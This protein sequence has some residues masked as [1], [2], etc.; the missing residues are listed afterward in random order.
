MQSPELDVGAMHVAVALQGSLRGDWAAVTWEGTKIIDIE[1][2][3]K[4]HKMEGLVWKEG[5]ER[6]Q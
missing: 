2:L 4:S 6:K 1:K 3:G 5:E